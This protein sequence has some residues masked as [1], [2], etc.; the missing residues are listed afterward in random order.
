VRVVVEGPFTFDERAKIRNEVVD[1]IKHACDDA[2]FPAKA[3]KVVGP[4]NLDA[5]KKGE[6]VIVPECFHLKR[7]ASVPSQEYPIGL[8]HLGDVADINWSV[9]AKSGPWRGRDNAQGLV[10][11]LVAEF[12]ELNQGVI[13]SVRMRPILTQMKWLNLGDSKDEVL[14]PSP[15]VIADKLRPL[16]G[17][18]ED[19]EIP[20]RVPVAEAH[21][22]RP[23][24]VVETRSKLV[25]HVAQKN[26]DLQRWERLGYDN[27]E[28]YFARFVVVL[29]QNLVRIVPLD[30]HPKDVV[31]FDRVI[32]RTPITPSDG[33]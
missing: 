32:A 23:P 15:P 5:W 21:T 17:G 29:G 33:Y 18:V 22:A 11:V 31:Y 3:R 9:H 26:A 13:E 1:E 28:N 12:G 30:P 19:R 6:L 16:L 4:W 14:I 8:K 2:R 24:K 20:L 27:P 7:G 25:D 10:L